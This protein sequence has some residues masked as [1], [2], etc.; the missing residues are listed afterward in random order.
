MSNLGLFAESDLYSER[1]EIYRSFSESEDRGGIIDEFISHIAKDKIVLD[2][3]CN[4]G[5]FIPSFSAVANKVVGVDKSTTAI[6]YGR[7]KYRDLKNVELSVED[8]T[9]LSL[10]D[11]SVDI[12][13]SSW[14]LGTILDVNLR[15]RALNELIR[16]TKSDGKILL[17]EN[18][19]DGEFEMIRGRTV[20]DGRTTG[21]NNWLI[22]SGFKE[23]FTTET[24]FQFYDLSQAHFIIEKIWGGAAAS[25]VSSSKIRHP[26]T[27]F[28][29]QL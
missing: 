20:E 6:D 28:E 25:R 1:L 29:W 3:G 12:T 10:E 23:L 24:Y 22:K 14:V 11:S 13:F 16:V 7:C 9:D 21:Y 8:L 4:F 19:P 18:S 26:I 17:I 15:K 27:I 2:A 5:R